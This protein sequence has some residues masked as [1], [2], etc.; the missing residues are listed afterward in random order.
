MQDIAFNVATG[1]LATANSDNT[2]QLWNTAAGLSIGI[3]L[4]PSASFVTSSNPETLLLGANSD[5]YV[6]RWPPSPSGNTEAQQVPLSR[7]WAAS[8]QDAFSSTGKLLAVA[9]TGGLRLISGAGSGSIR[10]LPAAAGT[11]NVVSATAFSP[12]GSLLAAANR[13]GYVTL[14]DT[15]TGSEVHTPLSAD[16]A[17]GSTEGGVFAIAFTPDGKLLAAA[18]V[19]GHVTFWNTAT[20]SAARPPIVADSSGGGVSGLAFSPDGKLL[21]TADHDGTARL[22]DLATGKLHATLLAQGLGAENFATAVAFS[23]DGKLFA[24]GYFDGTIQLWDAAA[25]SPI[26][27]LLYPRLSSSFSIRS[28]AFSPDSSLLLT[29][30]SHLDVTAWQLWQFANPYAALCDED[31]PPTQVLW[32]SYDSGTPEPAA[33]CAGVTPAAQL[34]G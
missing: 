8:P 29:S 12:D 11:G 33:T 18:G 28:L 3:P 21:A 13:Q 15:T 22:W 5:G 2:V 20:G 23:P 27:S 1:L 14:W 26:G 31:G 9:I 10:F 7:N 4:G 6:R 16:P 34:G 17:K 19:D 30:D 32:S 24:S 25:E